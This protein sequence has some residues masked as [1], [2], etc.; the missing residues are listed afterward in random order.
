MR[1][2]VQVFQGWFFSDNDSCEVVEQL[3]EQSKQL[4][5]KKIFQQSRFSGRDGLNEYDED[6]SFF[7]ARGDL[8]PTEMQ[9]AIAR[10]QTDNREDQQVTAKDND[11][12]EMDDIE[13]SVDNVIS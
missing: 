11:L 7:A 5:F 2:F 6:Y 8:I 1:Y 12:P 13:K 9:Q 10:L 3:A 4:A